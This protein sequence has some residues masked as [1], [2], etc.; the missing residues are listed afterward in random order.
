MEITG[1]CL[2]TEKQIF[3]NYSCSSV[4]P[5][6]KST[7]PFKALKK[8]PLEDL[9]GSCGYNCYVNEGC[10]QRT[11]HG[12][13]SLLHLDAFYLERKGNLNFV[14]I[15]DLLC[16]KCWAST[17]LDV[18]NHLTGKENHPRANKEGCSFIGMG[19]SEEGKKKLPF[20]R[21][22]LPILI[23]TLRKRYCHSPNQSMHL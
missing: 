21:S 23:S 6:F 7:E 19:E 2:W 4:S 3:V 9:D 13:V 11:Q 5:Y 15:S 18:L 10:E 1:W 17:Y 16:G 8:S 12:N 22:D 14:E 20:S